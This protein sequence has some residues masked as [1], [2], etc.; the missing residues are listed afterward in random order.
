MGGGAK[1]EKKRMKKGVGGEGKAG[2]EERVGGR[3]E[4]RERGR[5][6]GGRGKTQEG[7]KR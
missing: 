3:K 7:T 6:E 2:R 4:K 5:K 1:K